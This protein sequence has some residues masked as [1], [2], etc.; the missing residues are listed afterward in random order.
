MSSAHWQCMSCGA[1]LLNCRHAEEQITCEIHQDRLQ[2]TFEKFTGLY[3]KQGVNVV[4]HLVYPYAIYYTT[5]LI[6]YFKCLA[7]QFVE[8]SAMLNS[9]RERERARK[10]KRGAH[11][12]QIHLITFALMHKFPQLQ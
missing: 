5:F 2:L 3:L 1:D 10:G 6:L 11:H 9:E 7:L 12:S 8:M 4:L